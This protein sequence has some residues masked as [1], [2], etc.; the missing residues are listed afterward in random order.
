[1]D[2]DCVEMGARDRRV[3]WSGWTII[4]FNLEGTVPKCGL[5]YPCTGEPWE[6]SHSHSRLKLISETFPFLRNLIFWFLPQNMMIWGG[7]MIGHEAFAFIPRTWIANSDESIGCLSL[8]GLFLTGFPTLWHEA[9][10][11]IFLLSHRSSGDG[12][13]GIECSLLAGGFS[14][15]FSMY[16]ARGKHQY[17]SR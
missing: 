14:N 6:K 4:V 1:M 13:L 12:K 16:A 5:P 7:G 2:A 8:W 10:V 17:N 11:N 9:N 15:G 3:L